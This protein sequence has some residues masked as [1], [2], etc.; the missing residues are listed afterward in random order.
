ML[1]FK[2]DYLH[3]TKKLSL[4]FDSQLNSVL[5]ETHETPQEPQLA[6]R[7]KSVIPFTLNKEEFPSL[8]VYSP[9]GSFTDT[10]KSSALVQK[11]FEKNVFPISQQNIHN[12]I[13]SQKSNTRIEI[14]VKF[15]MTRPTHQSSTVFNKVYLGNASRVLHKD[16]LKPRCITT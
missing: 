6:Y 5:A 10:A 14:P 15:N 7:Y 12:F 9:L 16:V 11:S 8:S 13:S 4:L 1:L 3:L 2:N